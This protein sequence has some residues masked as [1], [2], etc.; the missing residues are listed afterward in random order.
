[1]QAILQAETIIIRRKAGRAV[2]NLQEYRCQQEPW[3]E[4]DEGEW[5]EERNEP[6]EDLVENFHVILTFLFLL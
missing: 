1:M 2:F 3:T 6:G 5:D 4:E